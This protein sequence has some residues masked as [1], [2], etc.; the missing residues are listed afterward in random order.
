MLIV[1]LILV[2]L[3]IS[4]ATKTEKFVNYK[5]VTVTPSKTIYEGI[6]LNIPANK[7]IYRNLARK[8]KNI[9]P[10]KH[11][12][13]DNTI[14]IIKNTQ[15]NNNYIGIIPDVMKIIKPD[16]FKHTRFISSIGLERFTLIT[17]NNTTIKNWPQTTNKI[18][19]VVENST[20]FHTLIYIKKMFVLSFKIVTIK[21]FEE[22]I[23]KDFKN[24]RF[25]AFFMIIAHPNN[26]LT[27]IHKELPLN[28]IGID[29]MDE[30]LITI[31]FPN[32]VKGKIDLT[33]YNIFNSQPDTLLVKLDVITNKNFSKDNGYNLIQTLFKN[34]LRIKSSGSDTYK[35]QMRDFNPE[36]IY[37]SNNNQKLHKGVYQFY[38]NIGLIT[39]NSE[40]S[41][42]YKVGVGECNIKK[43]NHFRLL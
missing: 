35:M 14:N 42:R 38:K 10:I 9:Y 16:Y 43:I 26:L 23:I 30:N 25:E 11:V 13:Y 19:G 28:F 36:Y 33:H 21:K 7:Y 17:P 27:K 5:T 24:K 2:I 18:I 4:Y 37:L 29:G 39:N 3:L 15:E 32:L 41:C 40:R 34:L 22:S 1:I 8:L 12:N 6:V 20:S 31:V